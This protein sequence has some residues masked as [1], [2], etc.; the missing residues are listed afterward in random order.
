MIYS[1]GMVINSLTDDLAELNHHHESLERAI[2]VLNILH[3]QIENERLGE[4]M[5]CQELLNQCK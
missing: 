2:D 1:D 4:L 3:T 5:A